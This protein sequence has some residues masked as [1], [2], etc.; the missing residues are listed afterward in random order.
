M[1]CKEDNFS[2]KGYLFIYMQDKVAYSRSEC[3]LTNHGP[4]VG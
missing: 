1:F 4:S 3:L 2:L